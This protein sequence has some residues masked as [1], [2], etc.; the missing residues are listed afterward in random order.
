MEAKKYREKSR[1]MNYLRTLVLSAGGFYFGYYIACMNAL[2][3]P[4]IELTLGYTAEK[5]PK[6]LQTLNGLVNLIFGSGALLGVII[7]GEIIK[8]IGRRPLLYTGEFIALINIAPTAIQGIVPFLFCRGISGLVAGINMTIYSIMLAELLP[9]DLCGIGGAL[10]NIFIAIGMLFSFV[11]QNIWVEDVLAKYWR[12]FMLYP[13]IFSVIRI[14][15]FFCLFKT[16]TPR[17]IFERS[18]LNR[19]LPISSTYQTEENERESKVKPSE[20]DIEGGEKESPKSE[21]LFLP[22]HYLKEM[23]SVY[24]HIYHK[25]DVNRVIKDH[26]LFWINEKKQG[27][28]SVSINQLFHRNYRR[29]LIAGCFASL[30]FQFSGIN[31]L[32]YYSTALF[33]PLSSGSG[34]IITL[35]VGLANILGGVATPFLIAR[36]G[37]KFNLIVGASFQSVGMILLSIGLKVGHLAPLII[38]TVLFVGGFSFGFGGTQTAY[39]SEVLPPSGVGVAIAVLFLFDCFISIIVP[40]M[41]IWVGPLAMMV[42][43]VIFNAFA[44]LYMWLTF[45]ETKDKLPNQIYEEFGK[46]WFH[47]KFK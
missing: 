46:G 44:A 28:G 45:V 9:N 47:L 19:M 39:I 4:I 1:K 11:C 16:D 37:R 12:V 29:Q 7:T 20:P 13:L 43:F 35:V 36:Q 30:A 23:E 38:G 15:L 6:L 17:Y 27:R 26:S 18:R 8:C 32:F 33:E 31:F 22:D 25:D 34:K 40:F 21:E 14:T 3:R 10:A 2:S 24:S 41:V 42:F 5:D